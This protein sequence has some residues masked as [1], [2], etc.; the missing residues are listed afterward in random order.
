[1]NSEQLSALIEDEKIASG[2]K[3]IDNGNAMNGI[4]CKVLCD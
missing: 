4:T 1:M 2:L 3:N